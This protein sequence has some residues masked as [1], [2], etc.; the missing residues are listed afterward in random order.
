[1]ETFDVL[2][3]PVRRRVLE[4]L[5]GGDLSAG[6]L[7]GRLGEEFG[8]SQPAVSQHLRVLREAGL[9][10]VRPDGSRRI[11]ALRT[12]PLVAAEAWLADLRR[13]WVQRL[14]S[15][16]TELLRGRRERRTAERHHIPEEDAGPSAGTARRMA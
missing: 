7:V 8:I 15:L 14:D 16:E 11:Y 4:H 1:M 12:E 2:G 6:A 3:E 5:A 10:E 13:F 9:V